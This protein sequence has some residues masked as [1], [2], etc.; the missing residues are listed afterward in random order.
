MSRRLR[1]FSISFRLLSLSQDHN[2]WISCFL[3]RMLQS[4][5]SICVL[6]IIY[7]LHLMLVM[8]Q[9]C[10]VPAHCAYLI[11]PKAILGNVFPLEYLVSK[12]FF[13]CSSQV[14]VPA[15]QIY[16]RVLLDTMRWSP[17]LLAVENHVPVQPRW[18]RHRP[19]SVSVHRAVTTSKATCW[20]SQRNPGQLHWES[21]SRQYSHL[22]VL[23]RAFLYHGQ[24]P[25][26][27]SEVSFGF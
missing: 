13:G 1:I 18:K 9:S 22:Q 4:L 12:R 14:L 15:S 23:H 26:R 6:V 20:K 11:S 21:L 24:S 25:A 7:I 3:P 16:V 27:P 8:C 2:S 10:S 19:F 5:H 17:D